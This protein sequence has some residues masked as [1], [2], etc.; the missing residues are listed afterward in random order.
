MAKYSNPQWRENNK[1]KW[2]SPKAFVIRTCS[3]TSHAKKP[4]K[5]ACEP[6]ID[7]KTHRDTK[8]VV[9]TL[10]PNHDS[11]KSGLLNERAPFVSYTRPD[12]VWKE[13]VQTAGSLRKQQHLVFSKCIKATE[14][15][16]DF[17]AFAKKDSMPIVEQELDQDVDVLD[18]VRIYLQNQNTLGSIAEAAHEPKKL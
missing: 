11:S 17:N 4:T 12:A 6:Y 7:I 5:I 10:T 2:V 8:K 13:R 1:A 3:S 18:K 9:T 14:K 15:M 16:D